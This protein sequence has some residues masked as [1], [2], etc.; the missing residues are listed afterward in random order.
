MYE[1]LEFRVSD[2]MTYHPVTIT[3][4]TTLARIEA[5]FDEHDFNCL[6][7]SE[8]GALLGIVTKLGLLNP[9]AFTPKTML[10][11]YADIMRRPAESVMTHRPT[12]VTSEVR[13]T[14]VLRMMTETRYHSFPVV[15][16]ALLIGMISRRDILRALARAVV[17]EQP[18]S[19]DPRRRNEWSG[20]GRIAIG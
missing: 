12:V 4:A 17:G 15:L 20:A 2:A 10:P 5:L 14:R 18:R 3:R 1:F 13:L 19:G 6:P 11:R 9:F 16:G 7:V 8:E